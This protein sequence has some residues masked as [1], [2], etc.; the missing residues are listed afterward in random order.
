MADYRLTQSGEEV[1][2]ILNHAVMQSE[3][4]AETER[5]TGKE[6]QLQNNINTVQQNLNTE[7]GTREQDDNAL[8]LFIQQV[9]G[10]L[11]N[12]YLKTQT[13]SANEIDQML[14]AIKQFRYQVVDQLP[15]PS[16][17]TMGIIYLVPSAHAVSGNIKDEYITLTRD[18]G[19]GIIYYF[20]QIGETRQMQRSRWPS[21][22][23]LQTITPNR[24]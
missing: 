19:S 14:A 1:Q 8:R 21:T 7:A 12:Y 11:V 9:Q 20:E 5:A 10:S 15:T 17:E 24:K 18:E 6:T 16:A 4:N 22:P 2:E 13:Y 3:L 23:P